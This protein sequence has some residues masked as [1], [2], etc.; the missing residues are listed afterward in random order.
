MMPSSHVPGHSV[1][2][3]TPDTD[4]RSHACSCHAPQHLHL[5]CVTRSEIDRV[6]PRK[7]L[8]VTGSSHL[9]LQ[10]FFQSV[11]LGG[12]NILDYIVFL[13][14]LELVDSESK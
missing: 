4:Q 11:T 9:N 1:S 6:H 13:K 2:T 5:Y 8:T 7:A 14:I 10:R 3:V 12:L